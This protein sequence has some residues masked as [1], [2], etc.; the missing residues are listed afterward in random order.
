MQIP[1]KMM[2]KDYVSYI[3]TASSLSVVDY[4]CSSMLKTI[5]NYPSHHIERWVLHP[6]KN[7][8]GLIYNN[9]IQVIDEKNR[10]I[11]SL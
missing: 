5:Y 2:S 3:G 1:Y 9:R 10:K 8:C 11:G 7:E 6:L 4:R